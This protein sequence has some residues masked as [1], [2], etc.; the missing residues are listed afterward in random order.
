MGTFCDSPLFSKSMWLNLQ[1]CG[2]TFIVSGLPYAFTFP[3]A[4]VAV[5]PGSCR[6]QQQ[7]PPKLL[8]TWAMRTLSPRKWS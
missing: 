3:S 2:A 4:C 7:E 6:L 5:G 8:S 1:S